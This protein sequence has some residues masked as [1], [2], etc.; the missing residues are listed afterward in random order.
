MSQNPTTAALEPDSVSGTFGLLPRLKI[1]LWLLQAGS[2]G[3]GPKH[4]RAR[5]F[6][7]KM[8]EESRNGLEKEQSRSGS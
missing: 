2:S 8:E 7:V 5:L 6:R 4:S 1:Q 3:K